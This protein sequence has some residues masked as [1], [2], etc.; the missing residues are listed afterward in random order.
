MAPLKTFSGEWVTTTDRTSVK[1]LNSLHTVLSLASSSGSTGL[2][3]NRR[4]DLRPAFAG[5]TDYE[6]LL[7]NSLVSKCT[8]LKVI[9]EMYTI[10]AIIDKSIAF[11]SSYFI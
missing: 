8:L 4:R 6:T 9:I 3:L 10:D 2:G 5:M 7:M 1:G 11:C